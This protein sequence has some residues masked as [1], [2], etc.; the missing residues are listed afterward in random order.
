MTTGRP[1]HETG[2]VSRPMLARAG[3]RWPAMCS[4]S[5]PMGGA[6]QGVAGAIDAGGAGC[7]GEQAVEILGL[8]D[9]AGGVVARG[10]DRGERRDAIGPVAGEAIEQA[11]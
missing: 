6:T 4:H 7:G 5:V 9:A 10:D 8:V 1:M 3:R 11:L 2:C